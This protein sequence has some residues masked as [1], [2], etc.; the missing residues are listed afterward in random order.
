MS[1][2]PSSR[3]QA[4]AWS[5]SS[6]REGARPKNRRPAPAPGGWCDA[7]RG[8]RRC[9]LAKGKCSAGGEGPPPAGGGSGAGMADAGRRELATAGPGG[10]P[11]VR[12][13]VRPSAL[14]LV[15]S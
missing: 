8:E 11:S 9:V 7:G 1:L 6:G 3:Y 13:L 2:S 5:V 12:L 4:A 10:G 15:C 14:P